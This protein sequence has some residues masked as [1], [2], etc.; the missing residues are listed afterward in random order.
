MESS[1]A[2]RISATTNAPMNKG[3]DTGFPVADLSINE[4]LGSNVAPAATE[5]GAVPEVGFDTA[6]HDH[7]RATTSTLGRPDIL[8]R[9]SPVS[10]TI[11]LHMRRTGSM[12]SCGVAGLPST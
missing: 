4:G 3:S 8:S 10:S 5:Q 9:A 11:H 12:P 1:N 2:E 6:M 7:P